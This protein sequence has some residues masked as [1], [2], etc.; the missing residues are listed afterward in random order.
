ML[1][2]CRGRHS[3]VQV[4]LRACGMSVMMLDDDVFAIYH[5][6]GPL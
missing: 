1:L 6:P 2:N 4:M 3:L 5:L